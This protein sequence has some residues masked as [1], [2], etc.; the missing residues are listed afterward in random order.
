LHD[1]AQAQMVAV[2]MKL[3]LA[4]KKLGGL[5]CGGGQADVERVL[6]LVTAAH[7]G[8]MEAISELRDL[9]GVSTPPCLTRAWASR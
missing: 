1:G 7:R 9:A 5:R 3:G 4:V 8:A 2:T 6:E